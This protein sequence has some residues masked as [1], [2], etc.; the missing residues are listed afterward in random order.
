MVVNSPAEMNVC[1]RIAA[2]LLAA[3]LA[4][5][6]A[7]AIAEHGESPWNVKTRVGPDAQVGGWFIN[8]GITGARVKLTAAEPRALEVMYVFPKTPAWGKLSPG[9][10]I[11]GAGGRRFLVPHKFGY[12][13][14]KFGYE[15]PLMDFA[16]ALEAAESSRSLAGRLR[17]MVVPKGRSSAK[18]VEVKVPTTYGAFSRTYPFNCRKTDL[19]LRQVYPYLL[20]RQ[21]RDGTWNGRPHINAFAALALLASGRKEYLPA[22]RK[23][24]EA[25]ART[26]SDKITYGGLPCW[27]Y[28]LGGIVL[29]EYYLATGEKWVL[30]ELEQINR[31]LAAAQSPR[32]GWGHAPWN[33]DGHN[34]YGPINVITMQAM[35]AWSLMGRCG[36]KVDP[37]RYAAAHEFVSRGTNS[38]GYVWYKDGGAQKR[39]YADMGRT[40]AAALAHYLCP[41]NIPAYRAYALRAARCIGAH[42]QTFVD[43]HGS[44]LLGMGWTALGAAVDKPSFRRLMDYNR[45]WFVLAHCPDGTFV[46]MPNRDNNPQDY[47]SAPRLSATAA[48]AL[49][50]SIKYGKLQLMGAPWK[51]PRR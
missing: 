15:G 35:L 5:P 26:T 46:Y 34:G 19:I 29:A 20:K 50:L 17:L 21:R 43:T 13:M 9:D 7:W 31:W 51:R 24:A 48:A 18:T 4:G 33:T 30:P 27:R 8:L 45:W 22:V 36:L 41:F 3:A 39:G 38:I 42:P 1:T 2:C 23:A 40:G 49:V 11:V 44:P 47:T 25:F 16:R 37:E 10:R 6:R 32:G 28:T 12:G 14:S